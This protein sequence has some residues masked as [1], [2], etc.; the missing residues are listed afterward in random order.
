MVFEE[1]ATC[2]H[3]RG[4]LSSAHRIRGHS[5]SVS[6]GSHPESAEAA[7]PEDITREAD[8]KH[9]ARQ[10]KR[11][12]ISPQNSSARRSITT[13][14]VLQPDTAA[15]AETDMTIEMP[16]SQPVPQIRATIL[17]QRLLKASPF[18]PR[19]PATQGQPRTSQLLTMKIR[20]PF[21]N[22]TKLAIKQNVYR[23]QMVR[24][25]ERSGSWSHEV[26]P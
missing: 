12:Q 8:E 16:Q 1:A 25:P 21:Q 17:N 20:K 6:I 10:Y 4:H 22:P 3:S 15:L 11:E 19:R 5:S 9:E 2:C 13:T 26:N 14:R 23:A 18:R 24:R 7:I